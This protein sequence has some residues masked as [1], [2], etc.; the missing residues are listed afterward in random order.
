MGDL[1]VLTALSTPPHLLVGDSR[2]CGGLRRV[3]SEAPSGLDFGGRG[4][5][6]C[7]AG[8]LFLGL[9][10]HMEKAFHL[11][12]TQGFPWEGLTL[13]LSF[14]KYLTTLFNVIKSL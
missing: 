9:P 14:G 1:S 2:V 13:A 4:S 11:L 8:S 5:D 3:A 6:R 10:F 7:G 12:C